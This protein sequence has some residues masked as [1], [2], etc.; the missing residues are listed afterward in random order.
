[1]APP[2]AASSCAKAAQVPISKAA[3]NAAEKTLNF[4]LH[5]PINLDYP[6]R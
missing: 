6:G 2:V 3:L 5:S 4:M 1:V